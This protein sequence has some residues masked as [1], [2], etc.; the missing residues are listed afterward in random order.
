VDS[1]HLKRL[2]LAAALCLALAGCAIGGPT[3]RPTVGLSI[4]A[5]TSGSVVGVRAIQLEGTVTPANAVV[6]VGHRTVR[7]RGGRFLQ[8]LIL[9]KPLTHITVRAKAK[10]FRGS[11]T[12]I[13]VH[14]ASRMF[15]KRHI[16]RSHSKRVSMPPAQSTAPGAQSTAPGTQATANSVQESEFLA[17]CDSRGGAVA[18]YCSCMWDRMQRAGLTSEAKLK[19]L[20][21]S[22][23]R[24]FMT[25]GVIVYPPALRKA[26]MGCLSQL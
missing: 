11:S 14:Y 24:S 9:L 25:K 12:V 22:W 5:P 3:G 15:A 1:G 20:A 13:A 7:V 10:G 4:V 21:M 19:A 23:R 2:W 18:G 26:V 6:Q 17:S 8:P 16:S